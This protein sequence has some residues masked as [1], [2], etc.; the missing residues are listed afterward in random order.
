M[1]DELEKQ[2]RFKALVEFEVDFDRQNDAPRALGA[3]MQSTLIVFKSE[4]GVV[5]LVDDA[6]KK[7]VEASV[8]TGADKKLEAVMVTWMPGWLTQLTAR[9]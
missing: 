6:M 1:L 2:H 5:R 4:K 3:T 9:F 7:P 8:S